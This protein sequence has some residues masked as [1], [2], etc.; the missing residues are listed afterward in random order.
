MSK[1]NDPTA[2]G[3]RLAVFMAGVGLFW[4]LATEIGRQYNWTQHTRLFFDLAALAAFGFGLW[5]GYNLWRDRRG[6]ED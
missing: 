3:R 5:L 1:K 6:D 2:R 4:I